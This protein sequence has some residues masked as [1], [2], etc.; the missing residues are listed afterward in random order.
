MLLTEAFGGLEDPRTGPARRHDLAEMIL[1]A[2]CAVLDEA[3]TRR[4]KQRRSG[5]TIDLPL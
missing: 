2:L 4:N 5:F 3:A 1:V